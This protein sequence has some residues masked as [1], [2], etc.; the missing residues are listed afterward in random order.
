MIIALIAVVSALLVQ[1]APGSATSDAL[2]HGFWSPSMYG[3][4]CPCRTTYLYLIKLRLALK[5]PSSY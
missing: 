5:D 1:P 2:V 4:Q 3:D